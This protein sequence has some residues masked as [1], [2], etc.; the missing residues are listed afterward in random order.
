M[1]VTFITYK[2]GKSDD[3]YEPCTRNNKKTYHIKHSFNIINRLTVK[4]T[5]NMKTVAINTTI[6]YINRFDLQTILIII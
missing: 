2:N 3:W 1:Q 4:I 6:V 5:Y